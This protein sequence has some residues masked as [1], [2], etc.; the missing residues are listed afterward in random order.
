MLLGVDEEHAPGLQ[1][2]LAH[3]ARLLDREYAGLG[4]QDHETVA[5]DP[6]ATRAQPVAVEHRADHGAVG[7]GH[8]CRTVPRLGEG[9]VELVE[10]AASR[11]HLGVVLPRLGDHHEHG[12]RKAAAAEMQ[13]LEHLVER[14]RVA[15]A[16]GADRVEPLE[17]ARDQIARELG[18]AGLHPVA[19][20]LDRVDLAVVCDEPV[21]VGQRPAREGVGREA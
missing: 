9:R 16:R 7:E 18:L 19:V 5:R 4:R 15:A 20:A 21:G 10:G 8:V 13:Q 2:P 3:D 6:V 14:R 12:V 17:V 11:V 1:T